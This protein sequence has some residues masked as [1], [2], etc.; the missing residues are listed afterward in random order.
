MSD[1]TCW[2]LIRDAAGRDAEAREVF[3][4]RYVPVL[5]RYFESRWR[6]KSALDVEDALQEVFVECFRDGGVLDRAGGGE[7]AEFR[8][9]LHGVARNVAGRLEQRFARR[10]DRPG[11]ATFH[12]DD[13]ARDEDRL[14][15]VFDRAWAQGLMRQAVRLHAERAN[16]GDAEARRRLRLL[17][18]RFQEGKPIRE[19]ARL[20]G[21]DPARLHHAYARAREEFG[22]ALREVVAY[23]QP[24]SPASVERECH[25]LLEILR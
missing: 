17:E 23:H 25:R 2:T 22:A 21:E 7:V 5:R 4:E 24:G 18:L 16:Q 9:F 20:W 12:A 13:L 3:V 11:T 8:A 15:V 19:I 1:E 6:T 14:T 10:R